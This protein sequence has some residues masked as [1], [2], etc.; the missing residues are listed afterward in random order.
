MNT[1]PFDVGGMSGHEDL[2]IAAE[3]L[4]Q[5]AGANEACIA[6]HTAINVSSINMSFAIPKRKYIRFDAGMGDVSNFDEGGM[7]V[8]EAHASR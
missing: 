2:I 7:I 4:P 8:S 6:C 3:E 5:M 1:T